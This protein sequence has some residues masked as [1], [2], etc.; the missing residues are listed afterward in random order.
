MF[1]YFALSDLLC[2]KSD[3]LHYEYFTKLFNLV[4][5]TLSSV[6]NLIIKPIDR[7]I[8]LLYCVQ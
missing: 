3:R 7:S 4:I 8:N 1:Y 2:A 5:V 6:V